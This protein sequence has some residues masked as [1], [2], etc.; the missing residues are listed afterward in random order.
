MK[1]KYT[2]VI[3]IRRLRWDEAKLKLMK[4]LDLLYLQGVRKVKIIHGKG[5]GK[6]REM[7]CE[8]IKNQPFVEKFNEA[9]FF[10]GGPG[11]TIVYLK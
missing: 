1:T 10:E 8:Y 7:V 3:H 4:E 2:G 6:L 9:P 11:V 5:S